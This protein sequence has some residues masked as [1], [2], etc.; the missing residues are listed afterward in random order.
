MSTEMS[1]VVVCP[2]PQ[3]T[4]AMSGHAR[5]RSPITS[6]HRPPLITKSGLRMRMTRRPRLLVMLFK[7]LNL[8]MAQLTC[9]ESS[10]S[11]LL[12]LHTT[13]PMSTHTISVSLQSK[14]RM[15]RWPAS[16]S[17]LVEVW[18]SHTTTRRHTRELEASRAIGLDR[19]AAGNVTVE[20]GARRAHTFALAA[21]AC[22]L[23]TGLS[24]VSVRT[25]R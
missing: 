1:C 4:T 10:R 3:S 21:A 13:T 11:P 2:P 8:C 6:Y 16:T 25:P 7:T 18:V 22:S 23:S 5:R 15:V 12:S 24:S 17:L 14:T 19:V 9:P 20:R